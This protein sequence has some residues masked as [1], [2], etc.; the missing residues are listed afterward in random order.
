MHRSH[1]LSTRATGVLGAA[2][3]AATLVSTSAQNDRL[4]VQV[5]DLDSRLPIARARVMSTST[6]T[7]PAVFTDVHGELELEPGGVRSIRVTKAGYVPQPIA[8]DGLADG[9]IIALAR[10]A[11]IGGRVLDLFGAAV[12]GRQ[13]VMTDATDAQ[14]AGLQ[15]RRYVTASDDMGEYRVGALPEG[16][17]AV[18]LGAVA[19]GAAQ[20]SQGPPP[21]AFT[22]LVAVRR[23]DEVSGIDFIASARMPCAAATNDARSARRD[24]GIARI[25]GR[26]VNRTGQ[27]LPCVEVIAFRGAERVASAMTAPDGTY[28]LT[29]LRPG[30]YQIEFRRAGFV[31]LQWGR[32]VNGQP[33]RPVV[34][35]GNDVSDV[36]AV[37]P[38]G[39]AISG[40]LYDEFGE[41]SENVTVRALELRGDDD[42]PIAVGVMS[43]AT[44][45]R[46]R[47]RLFG[48]APG[49]YIVAT[50]ASNDRPDPHTGKG[51]APAY[52]PG[53]VEVASARPVEVQEERDRQWTDFAREPV[54]VATVSG[55]AVDSINRPVTER[56]IL[57]ASQRSGAV[58]AETQGAEVKGSEGAFTIPNVPPGDYVVQATSKRS[59][60]GSSL[61]FGMQ[62][63]TVYEEDPPPARVKTMPGLDVQGRLLQ[64]GRPLT[65]PRGFALTALPV[66]WDQTSLLA[67]AQVLAPA[68]DGTIAMEGITGPRRLVLTTT[69]PGWYLKSIRMR[70][71][72]VTDDATGFPLGGLGFIRDL[73]VTMS[74]R[75][76][77]VEGEVLSGSTRATDYSV[78]L[79]SANPDH[80][81]RNSRFVK[82]VRGGDGGRFRIDG[83]ADGD[84]YVAATE[85]LD[86]SAGGAWQERS[87]LQSL[88]NAARRLRLRE[89]DD[90]SL[91]LTVTHR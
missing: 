44:D 81:F 78:V 58:I 91:T 29:R 63:V 65:D 9:A 90:R 89:G 73:E 24:A 34:L 3:A 48:L 17:Y 11:G 57:V 4:R 30:A 54:R 79:F 22:H 52:Y 31:T 64:D 10:G 5:V 72:N 2:L 25:A 8:I 28:A 12:A 84:Y 49:R 43:A 67:G 82:S 75:G 35:R 45:D 51:Y 21:D 88:I 69:P 80:W 61:E 19:P 46:G 32:Q 47:Y 26:V 70:G 87:Y 40:T 18:S 77:V 59:D 41:P 33:G 53:A 83:V 60:G 27:A 56:V 76:A 39:G 55:F 16:R 1:V 50:A 23:G 62:Y 85:P 6:T 37:L 36:D 71:R 74:N 38:R 66:D 86:G 42:R 7:F 15:P 14:T 68:E 13:I 20:E